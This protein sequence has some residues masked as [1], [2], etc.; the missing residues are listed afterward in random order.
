MTHGKMRD[1]GAWIDVRSAAN[2]AGLSVWSLYEAVASNDLRHV[3]V[4][5][6]RRIRT[7]IVWVDEWLERH[8]SRPDDGQHEDHRTLRRRSA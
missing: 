3:R 8:G 1:S 2:H 7:R 4:G 5:G 6:R